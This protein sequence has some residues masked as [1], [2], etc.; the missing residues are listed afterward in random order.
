MYAPVH[1]TEYQP[2]SKYDKPCQMI[3]FDISLHNFFFIF[4]MNSPSASSVFI[5]FHFFHISLLNDKFLFSL[6]YLNRTFEEFKYVQND[7][8]WNLYFPWLIFFRLHDLSYF[9]MSTASSKSDISIK[10]IHNIIII[11]NCMH[12]LRIELF[13][14]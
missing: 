4:C 2:I 7:I 14:E 6:M 3:L 11:L 8:L 9:H 1:F 13:S 10:W 12:K 5:L